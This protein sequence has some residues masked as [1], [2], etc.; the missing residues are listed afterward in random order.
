MNSHRSDWNV[1]LWGLS[2]VICLTAVAWDAYVQSPQPETDSD[3]L[4]TVSAGVAHTCAVRWDGVLACWGHDY[5][6]QS[7]P[8]P[9]TFT[10]VSA[11]SLHSCAVRTDSTLAC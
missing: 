5:F 2:L 8:L 9:S 4:T 1:W 11:G 10:A 6:G 3:V 7:I